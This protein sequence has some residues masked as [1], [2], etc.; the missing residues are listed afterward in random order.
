MHCKGICSQYAVKKPIEKKTG[1]YESGHKRCS[2]CEIYIVWPE[3]NC[4]C[5]GIA[6]RAKPR[7]A[8]GRDKIVQKAKIGKF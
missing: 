3:R 1:R 5:C 7:N 2:V 4:P 6:L 8:K